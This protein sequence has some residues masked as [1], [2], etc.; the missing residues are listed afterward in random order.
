M[1]YSVLKVPLNPN[2]P[3]NPSLTCAIPERLRYEYHGKV[4]Y[5]FK[6]LVCFNESSLVIIVVFY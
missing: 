3:T 4:L 6:A 5:R 1:T 2:Q